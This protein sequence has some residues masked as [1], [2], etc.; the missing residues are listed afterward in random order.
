MTSSPGRSSTR[1]GSGATIVFEHI[2]QST[3]QRSLELLASGGR[4]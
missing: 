1:A 4:S 2:G 3:W